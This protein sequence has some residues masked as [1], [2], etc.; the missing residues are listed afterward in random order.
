MTFCY[1]SHVRRTLLF[2]D[3]DKNW[4]SKKVNKEG[5]P[6]L[7]ESRLRYLSNADKVEN[8]HV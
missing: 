7:T 5:K 1:L 3:K 2:W 6:I 8:M 4:Q